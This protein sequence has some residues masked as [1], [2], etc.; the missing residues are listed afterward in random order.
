[1]TRD[2]IERR[3]GDISRFMEAMSHGWPFLS[4]E[5]KRRA[6]DLTESLVSTNNEETR[7]RIKQLRDVL[8]MPEALASERQSL[9][10][11]LKIEE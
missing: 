11:A 9:S 2:D 7:G 1:M 4:A 10:E 3:I 6:D 5:L 8:D